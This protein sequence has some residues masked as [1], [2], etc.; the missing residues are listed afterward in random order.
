MP[1]AESIFRRGEEGLLHKIQV[2]VEEVKEQLGNVRVD[3]APGPD[4]M[5][6]RVLREVAEQ[7][8]ELLTNIF[9]SSLESVQVPEDWRVAYVTPLFKKGSREE[10]GY[11]RPVCLTS[12]V[13]K[14]LETLIRDQM[15]NHLNK[16]KLIKSARVY[17]R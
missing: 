13:G 9:N 3:K 15:R 6:P 11:Y 1:I 7:V 4:N 12:V 14:V 8:S 16:Y 5:E 17:Q 10:L 2:E